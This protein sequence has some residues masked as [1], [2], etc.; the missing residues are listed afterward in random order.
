MVALQILK[1][2]TNVWDLQRQQNK[3]LKLKLK[4]PLK[5]ILPLVVYHGPTGWKIDLSFAALFDEA[6][7]PDV[8]RPY[9]PNFNYWL[10]DLSQYSDEDIKGEVIL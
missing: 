5:P 3:D 2:M 9:I 6:D 1:Y 7:L 8:L 4:H 10:V